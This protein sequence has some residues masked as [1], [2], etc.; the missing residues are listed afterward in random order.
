MKRR[1]K[2]RLNLIILVFILVATTLE[3]SF[4]QEQNLVQKNYDGKVL[5]EAYNFTIV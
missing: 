5:E 4:A 2:F 1:A 3:T